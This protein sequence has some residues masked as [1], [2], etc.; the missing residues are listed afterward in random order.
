[1]GI[2]GLPT[3]VFFCKKCVMS[4]QKVAPSI[5]TK[6]YRYSKKSTLYF[7]DDCICEP[8]RIH[9]EFDNKINWEEREQQLKKLLDKYRSTD[10]SYDCIV[11]GSGGKDSVFQSLMLKEKYGMNP[12]TVTWA[13]HI[14]TEYG[15]KN[16]ENFMLSLSNSI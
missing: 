11:P 2:Y 13:P 3:K 7:D 9:E 5:I 14:Y 8:C 4:N 10:G 12:L 15:R 6:D 1:M 16:F